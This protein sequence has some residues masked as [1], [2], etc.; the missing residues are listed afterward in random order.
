[1]DKT[2]NINK[3]LRRKVRASYFISTLSIA[4]VLFLLGSAGYLIM[5]ALKTADMIEQ[6]MT[7][8]VMLGDNLDGEKAAGIGKRLEALENVREVV[9]VPKDEAAA[10]FMKSE[11]R[12]FI[13]FLGFNPLPDSYE[14][15]M[16]A[17]HAGKED[18]AGLEKEVM[19]W[20]GV[21]E[22]VYQKSVVDRISSNISKFNVIVLLFGGALLVISLILLNNT[23]RLTIYSKRYLINTMK[24]V[25]ASKWFIMKPFVGRSIL[26]GIYAWII[27]GVLFVGMVGALGEGVPEI[28]MFREN[29]PIYITLAAMLVVGMLI[30]VLFTTFAANKFVNMHSSKIHLY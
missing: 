23:I 29:G 19:G 13:E 4:L 14:V 9:F 10:E 11:G 1:M 17:G 8:Y 25:G 21:D 27:A 3:S 15:K 28:T 7:I 5:S 2:D 26:H 12:D 16:K 22:V 18:I 30:S 24:M 20:S 6:N